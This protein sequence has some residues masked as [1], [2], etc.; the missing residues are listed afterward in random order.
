MGL[1]TAI[2]W[3]D[4]TLNLMMGCD[5]CELSS[6][7]GSGTCYAET[8]TERYGG[9]K[10][11]PDS[12]YQPALFLE[13]LVEAER[14]P[15]LTGK[16]RPAK[17]W[18]SGMPR[19][20]FHGD[21]GD[22]WTESLPLDWLAP[23]I[24][25][26]AAIPAVHIFLTKRPARMAKF[27][28]EHGPAPANAILMTSVTSQTQVA[29]VAQLLEAPNRGRFGLSLEPLLGPIPIEPHLLASI[30][31]VIVGGESGPGA[32][33]MHP[34]WVRSLRDQCQA[35]G[36]R[37]FFKQWGNWAPW[38][39]SY[40]VLGV[41]HQSAQDGATGHN[42]GYVALPGGKVVVR[43]D[44]IPMAAVG[45][46]RAGRLLDGREWTEMPEVSHA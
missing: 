44:T 19:H 41:V 9:R 35:A 8:L 22:Y 43:A 45:K 14:W 5:G 28:K 37:F 30:D 16:E 15:D 11:Y 38:T 25:R 23:H 2:E 40:P 31:W 7:A 12:F 39:P 18:L 1:T 20:I 21:M 4:S 29:R 34:E 36:V 32:R 33:P 26:I 6:R 10:G 3:S 42:P 13:R 27:W 24:E 17:P 46:K